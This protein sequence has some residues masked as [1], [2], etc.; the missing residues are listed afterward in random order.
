MEIA[1]AAVGHP[2]TLL[3]GQHRATVVTVTDLE[4]DHVLIGEANVAD[5]AQLVQ[6]IAVGELGELESQSGI[7]IDF[8]RVGGV[9]LCSFLLLSKNKPG[10]RT[11]D[12]KKTG[13]PSYGRGLNIDILHDS[14]P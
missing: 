9:N 1:R 8:R 2:A 5:R 3:T 4:Q 10:E 14:E 13:G 12:E 7:A 11:R 6:R